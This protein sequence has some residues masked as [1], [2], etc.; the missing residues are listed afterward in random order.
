MGN[1]VLVSMM[2]LLDPEILWDNWE[3]SI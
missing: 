2:P 3:N 1:Q